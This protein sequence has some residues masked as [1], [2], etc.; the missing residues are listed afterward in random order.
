MGWMLN[1]NNKITP[2]EEEALKR[3]ENG[4]DGEPDQ[5]F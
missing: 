5:N 4:W 3:E 1:I 2:A